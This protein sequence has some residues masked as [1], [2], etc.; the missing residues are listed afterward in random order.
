MSNKESFSADHWSTLVE[1]G[2]A[3]A[4]AVSFSAGSKGQSEGEMAAYAAFVATATGQGG[5]SLVGTLAAEV[6]GWLASPPPMEGSDDPF[7][8][9]LEVARKAGAILAVA[10]DPADAEAL[11][12]WYLAGADAVAQAAR[13][14][15]ILGL[16]GEQLSAWEIQTIGSIRDALGAA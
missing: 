7:T 3:I 15:G 12:A 13:E 9:G 10:S 14:G 4:R 8:D 5:A 2:P 16:G 1:A 11:I 6:N